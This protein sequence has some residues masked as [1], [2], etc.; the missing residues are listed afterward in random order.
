MKR[1]SLWSMIVVALV[2]QLSV[3]TLS[4]AQPVEEPVKEKQCD[5]RGKMDKM[6]VDLGVN[7]EQKAK[8]DELFSTC[9]P[10]M[11]KLMEAKKAKK[12]ELSTLLQSA[13]LDQAKIDAVQAELKALAA[14][15]MDNKLK[16]ML[17]VREI[18]TPEQFKVF[19]EKKKDCTGGK[20]YKKDCGC[21]KKDCDC[22]KKD[23]DCGKKDCDCGK[24]SKKDCNCGKKCKKDC[25]LNMKKDKGMEKGEDA[26]VSES[27]PEV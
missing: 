24:K 15:K 1:R 9:K 13:E 14:E 3:V 12:E 18:L 10:E 6:L 19:L 20:K 25:P 21:G 26:E 4:F 23:C 17:A 5:M 7:D 8:M 2:V 27:M 11:K 16:K 22:G